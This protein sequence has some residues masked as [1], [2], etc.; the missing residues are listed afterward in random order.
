MLDRVQA[1]S[2]KSAGPGKND[3]ENSDVVLQKYAMCGL[4]HCKIKQHTR[5]QQ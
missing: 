1:H 4:R 2:G 5:S 3:R